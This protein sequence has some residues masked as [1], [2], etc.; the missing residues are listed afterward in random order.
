MWL[1]VR[2]I[3]FSPLLPAAQRKTEAGLYPQPFCL[4]T[5]WGGV[6]EFLAEWIEIISSKTSSLPKKISLLSHSVVSSVYKPWAFPRWTLRIPFR[7]CFFVPKFKCMNP[8]SICPYRSV[9]R[10]REM[11]SRAAW[12]ATSSTSTRRREPEGCGRCRKVWKFLH[13]CLFWY[14]CDTVIFF[15]VRASL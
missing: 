3:V 9:C 4:K 14:G 5:G 2:N 7:L 10:L 6:G 15:S 11:W 13:F 12:W 1:H 8:A